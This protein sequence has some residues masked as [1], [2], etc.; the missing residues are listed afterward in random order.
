MKLINFVILFSMLVF[1][2]CSE[3]TDNSTESEGEGKPLTEMVGT[4]IFS[5][6]TVDGNQD[7]LGTV[8]GWD[9]YAVEAR[10]HIYENG[11]YAFEQVDISGG[12]L[13]S[14]SGF[15]YVDENE[16]EMDINVQQVNGTPVTET[17]AVT[18]ILIED[19]FTVT[20]NEEGT[21]I[22]YT[23]TRKT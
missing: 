15:I 20:E 2:S 5:S 23:L 16:N 18:Y 3:S 11:A 4:W 9:E 6:V 1:F 21:L 19:T 7:S 14:E 22:T 8:M 12:Q 10:F 13:W 17:V